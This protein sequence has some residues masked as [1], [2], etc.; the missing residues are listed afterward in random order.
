MQ[1]VY[2]SLSCKRQAQVDTLTAPLVRSPLT[3]QRNII[4]L[5]LMHSG[6]SSLLNSILR[7]LYGEWDE[8]MRVRCETGGVPAGE[9]L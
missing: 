5:G 1:G 7:V 9:A 8:A 6:K 3:R 2:S 4:V